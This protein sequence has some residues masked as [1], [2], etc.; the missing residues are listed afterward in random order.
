LGQTY[1]EIN[2]EQLAIKCY[3]EAIQLDPEYYEAFLARGYCYDKL[4][5]SA[6]VERFQSGNSLTSNGEDA[7]Y[8]KADLEYSLGNLQDSINS[9]ESALKINP[10]N[11]SAWLKLAETNFEKGSWL[12]AL[13]AYNEC[14]KIKPAHASS[15]YGKAKIK[16]LLNQT[17][18]AI[19]CLK[20][21]FK[22]DPNIKTE[23]TRDYP[24]IKSSKLFI[25]LLEDNKS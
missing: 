3:T 19:E 17:Q 9:Y 22:L 11:F 1:E 14:I 10:V 15:F 8:A 6:R 12:E 7:W 2:S 16:F 21:A 25:K 13:S 18:E 24:E 20:Y 5:I 4:K 23:F